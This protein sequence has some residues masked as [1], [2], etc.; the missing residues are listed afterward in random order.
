MITADYTYR[1]FPERPDNPA[2][3]GRHGWFDSRS[4]DHAIER[5]SEAMSAPLRTVHW[6]RRIE[7]LDQGQLGSCT[8]NAGTGALGTDPFFDHV[9]AKGLKLDESYAVNLY[10][11]ATQVDACP[12]SY[13][14]E[15]TGSSGLAVCKVLKASNIISGYR[16]ATTASGLV[17]LLQAGPVLLGMPW[18]EAFFSP[19]R[20]GFIDS[21]RWQSSQ[22]AGGHEVEIVGVDLAPHLA[23]SVLTLANS[24][25]TGWGD[26]GFFRMRLS[27]YSQLQQADLKQY[28]MAAPG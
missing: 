4:L 13:P 23:E 19:D 3:L 20:R 21:A 25:G 6:A 5:D 9:L 17:R 26:G 18:Y 15:D 12:G 7:I 2:R 8:G 28:L 27:T 14:P 10:S 11:A 16:W 24:W 22:L 1:A